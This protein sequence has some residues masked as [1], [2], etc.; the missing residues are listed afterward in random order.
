MT[1]FEQ[2]GLAIAM[3][4]FAE[5]DLDQARNMIEASPSLFANNGRA[6]CRVRTNGGSGESP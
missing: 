6:G 4:A 5:G 1:D 3:K 2:Q